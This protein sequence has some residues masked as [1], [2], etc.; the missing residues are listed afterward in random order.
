MEKGEEY[1]YRFLELY[2]YSLEQNGKV[3]VTSV[4]MHYVSS[5][6]LNLVSHRVGRT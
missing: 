5:R 2:L 6:L 4:G 1:G 3:Y